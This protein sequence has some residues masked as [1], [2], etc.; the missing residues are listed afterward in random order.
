MLDRLTNTLDFH[1][2]AL[3]LRAERQQVLSGNIANSDTPGFLARDFDFGKALRAASGADPLAKAVRP[4]A[5]GGA[6][7]PRF[8]PVG[9]GP[10]GAAA[11]ARMLYRTPE[12]ASIDGNTV[13]LD[14][15]RANFADNAVRY[16]ATL[17]FIDGNV[18]T[19]LSAIKGE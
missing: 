8:L 5:S 10:T 3:L 14:R 16:Q 12:Q 9:L 1:G 6:Q 11:D 15:E 13:D 2:R 4:A 18:R 19:M 17:R 7:D